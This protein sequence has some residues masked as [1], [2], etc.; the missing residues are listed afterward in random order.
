MP[1]EMVEGS[2][3]LW[4]SVYAL[5]GGSTCPQLFCYAQPFNAST[6]QCRAI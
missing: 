3:Y 1:D 6:G 5:L 4:K 2:L